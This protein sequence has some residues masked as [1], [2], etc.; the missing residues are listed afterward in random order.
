M[1]TAQQEAFC[2]IHYGRSESTQV[3]SVHFGLSMVFNLLIRLCKQ[4]SEKQYNSSKIKVWDS[5]EG[6]KKILAAFRK[7]LL[8][9][10]ENR[11][12]SQAESSKF[13]NF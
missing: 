9:V 10:Q 11:P 12:A 6:G 8:A 7:H 1:K 3:S 4:F 2:V 5:S 13:H